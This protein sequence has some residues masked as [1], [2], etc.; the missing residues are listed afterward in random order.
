MDIDCVSEDTKF[1]DLYQNQVVL[2]Q[3]NYPDDLVM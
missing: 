1:I 2:R 3:T